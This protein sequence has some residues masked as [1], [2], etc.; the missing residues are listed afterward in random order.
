MPTPPRE[1]GK[2][3]SQTMPT[4]TTDSG[5]ILPMCSTPAGE[6]LN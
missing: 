2:N 4:Y 1:I 5:D 3:Y 6:M